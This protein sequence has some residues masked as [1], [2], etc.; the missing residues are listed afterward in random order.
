M[1]HYLPL[2]PGLAARSFALAEPD[3]AAVTRSRSRASDLSVPTRGVRL[4]RGLELLSTAGLAGLARLDPTVVLSHTTAAKLWGIPVPGYADKAGEVHLTHSPER[5]RPRRADFTGHRLTLAAEDIR[6]LG[7]LRLTSPER[8]WLDLAPGLQL[9]DLIAAGDAVV[10]AHTRGFGPP[11]V[12]LAG[13]RELRAVVGRNP[14]RRGVVR[15]RLALEEVRVGADSPP[16]TKLRLALVRSGLP[17][18]EL[19]V[20]VTDPSGQEVLWPDLAYRRQRVAVEYDGAHHGGED[21]YLKDIAREGR[22]H[23]AGWLIVRIGRDDLLSEGRPAVRKVRG[24]L[25]LRLETGRAA[26]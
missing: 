26:S 4:P 3:A 10:C 9:D 6:T 17:E 8:T 1:P 14:G 16:E 20:A 18:P 21:Q 12:A 19:N 23:R 24:A 15:A 2:P 5:N 11:K 25:A 22:A 7:G 13:R